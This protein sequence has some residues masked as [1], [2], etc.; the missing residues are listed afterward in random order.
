MRS[1]NDIAEGLRRGERLTREDA[2]KMW[3]EA[4]LWLL[5]ELATE[6]KR[7]ASGEE[8]YYNRNIHLEPSNI[9]L[10]N[11]EFCSF[12]RR[13]GDP[14]AWSMTI[15][16]VEAR[17]RE[18]QGSGITEVHIV[19]GVHPRHDL[20]TYCAMVRAVKRALPEVAVKAYTAVEILYMTRREGVSIVEGLRRLKEAGMEAIPG[21]GAEIFDEELRA[22]ICPEKCSSEEWL[23]VHRA[24]HNMGIN[25]NCTM[26]YGHVESLEQRV[27]HLDRL[28]T[29]QDVAPGFDAFI[30]L[31]YRS[32]NNRMS[33]VGECSVEEDL[34]MI[35]MSRL[36]L[37]NIQH[38]KAY[39]VAY[40]KPTTEMAL[41]FGADDIDGTIDDSTKI[42]SMAGADARPSMTAEELCEL[43]RS[44]GFVPVERDTHYN[45]VV[46]S[47]EPQPKPVAVAQPKPTPAAQPKPVEVAQPKPTHAAQP[48][49][50]PAPA[51]EQKSS[52]EKKESKPN[53]SVERKT[54]K[55]SAA[56]PR[57]ASAAKS[58]KERGTQA[59][60]QARGFY[61][62]HPLTSH[63]IL[64]GVAVIILVIALHIGLK[65]GTRHGNT[66]AVP[67]FLGEHVED[68]KQRAE[69]MGLNIIIRD[70]VFDS[71]VA[72]GV[73]VDQL[74]R[75]S[76]LRTVTVK[77][78]RKI[79][80]TINAYNR[81]MVEVPYVAKQ[82][83]RQALNQ[84]QRAGL[85]VDKLI[86][87]PNLTSTDYVLRQ[88]V[89]GRDITAST[90]A[91]V[92]FGTG[93]TLYVSY[94]RDEQ[95]TTVPRL[96]GM[97][98]SQ[99]RST[100]WDRGLNL[101][102][103]VYDESVEDFKSRRAA[104]VYRQSL[105]QSSGANRGSG[106]TLYMTVDER[107]VDSLMKLSDR[108]AKRYEK[109][110]RQEEEALR[111]KY[112]EEAATAAESGEAEAKAEEESFF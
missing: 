28:R 81:R 90:S 45:A 6:R 13:E 47:V 39:W 12:R 93:V 52:D 99:A 1:V 43:V 101:T 105:H 64:I 10:F 83:L 59:K 75:T 37:D 104:M 96:V 60:Q 67:S 55:R 108:D 107:L 18:M 84:L 58:V 41:A 78:G 40:G 61:E 23:A 89:D 11:C 31:K 32:R 24:A 49:P 15:E 85:V 22:K 102:E 109:Q 110:R 3:R 53:M 66:I 30:P 97:R 25:T 17:A 26:L 20:D 73:V 74:P 14:D 9:C 7:K 35:A 51:T 29:L 86:Y 95:L 94:R 8:V 5:G 38:I 63:L 27:D 70:S 79:Y 44:A 88:V 91:T 103:V 48:K 111:L 65:W 54:T 57:V 69:D 2:L 112:E 82:T 92:P 68:V 62:R 56:E 16:Q 21:G 71:D 106:I 72:G 76:S 33:A 42:Y 34:R 19:G 50:A 46:R 4:P 100:I 87:E 36:Y 77:P 80:V 98:L